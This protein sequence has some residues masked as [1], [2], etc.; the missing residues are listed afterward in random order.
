ME[1]ESI[2]EKNT[3]LNDKKWNFDKNNDTHFYL[4]VL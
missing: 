1:H 3:G 2:R 4:G